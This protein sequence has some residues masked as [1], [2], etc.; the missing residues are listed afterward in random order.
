MSQNAFRNRII[1]RMACCREPK[2]RSVC[3]REA[4]VRLDELM[5]SL[6]S[7]FSGAPPRL[8]PA[9]LASRKA[10]ELGGVCVNR[11][12]LDEFIK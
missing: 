11:V 3:E 8:I 10:A 5:D 9:K 6:N 4:A 2:S 12:A 7:R 1:V